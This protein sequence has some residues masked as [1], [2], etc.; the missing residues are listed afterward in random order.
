MVFI[1]YEFDLLKINNDILYFY[2]F[3]RMF[4]TTT[5][6][7]LYLQLFTLLSQFIYKY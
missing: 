1:L 5:I 6:L 4:I 2:K 7:I 3:K